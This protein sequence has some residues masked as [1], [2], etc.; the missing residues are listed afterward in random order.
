L[1]SIRICNNI[2][3]CCE[4]YMSNIR[5]QEDF[6]QLLPG[7]QVG[8]STYVRTAGISSTRLCQRDKVAGRA[9]EHNSSHY[10][11]FY[12]FC[13]FTYLCYLLQQR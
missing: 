11:Y 5:K 9:I 2:A 3:T 6:F 12:Y 1:S 4:W 13:L 8:K 10:H 7:I